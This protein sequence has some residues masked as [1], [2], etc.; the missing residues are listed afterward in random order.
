MG[1][2]IFIFGSAGSGKSTFCKKLTEHGKLIHRQINV[3]NLD[4]AQIGENHDYIIDIRDY[5][6]TADIME[7]CDFGP[8]GSVMIAFSELYNNIDVI[9]VEDLSN[10][11]LVFDCP[12]QIELFMH[13]NDFLNIVEYFSKFFRI[14]ILYFIESQSIND[15]GKFLGNILCGYI[16][17]SRFNVF[18]SFVLTKV[19]LIG[20]ETV[21]DFLETLNDK[22]DENLLYNKILDLVNIDFKLLDYSDEDS[23]NDLLYWI[24]NNLQYFD[25]LD[26]QKDVE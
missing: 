17:M 11:Y 20:K 14:G 4:P 1:H 21:E 12:G 13:S 9:D 19:D 16:S 26:V 3:V 7:E 8:N 2:A 18:M 24:D 25:D 15:V 22:C 5:I 23:I 10:E 6:T